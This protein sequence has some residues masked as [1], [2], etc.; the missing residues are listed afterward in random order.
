MANKPASYNWENPTKKELWGGD[1]G[2]EWNYQPN[3][4]ITEII[5]S[6]GYFI[7]AISFKSVDGE[8]KVH[9]SDKY[10]GDG[11]TK[12]IFEIHWPN[13]YL[14]SISGTYDTQNGEYFIRSLRF[15]TKQGIESKSYGHAFGKRF[16][17]SMQNGIIVGFYGRRS[18]LLDAIGV[19]VKPYANL[20]CLTS[21]V[22]MLR[23]E[24]DI[25]PAH[26]LLNV[27]SYSLLPID[28]EE[29]GKYESKFYEFEGY[30]YRWK[31]ILYPNGDSTR[32]GKGHISLYLAIDENNLARDDTYLTVCVDLK[33]FVL[34]NDTKKYL[35]IQDAEGAI[36]YFGKQRTVQGFS[37]LLSIE[38]FKDPSNGYLVDDACT[39]GAE[40]FIIQPSRRTRH[41]ALT[42]FKD[43]L[44][45]THNKD[46]V[47]IQSD[48]KTHTWE[49][50]QFLS[51]GNEEVRFNA[52]NRTW[53]LHIFPKGRD[54]PNGDF[55][56]L[57]LH[58]N[59]PS[60]KVY[61]KATVR[62]VDHLG[63]G[64]KEK[65]ET[66][67][68]W[69]DET[70]K[71]WDKPDITMQLSDIREYVNMEGTLLLQVKFDVISEIK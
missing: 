9:S 6:H 64:S 60:R 62:V 24:R 38:I 47:F 11:G 40:F 56:S 33:F 37:Q 35:T 71:E 68:R 50:T 26:L 32:N 41:E 16:E 15:K 46:R 57:Y 2:T 8:G 49:I 43:P 36:M 18:N 3:G 58:V 48:G 4:P 21:R 44:V 23:E 70:E 45:E 17:Y 5:V 13:D 29:R 67:S 39:F 7:D 22:L 63:N 31:L 65:E 30:P 28:T 55:M 53:F 59:D 19:Y 12:D 66:I 27:K 1:G 20:Y 69:Y 61:V 34:N 52:A 25:Q 54:T 10:G 51:K 14:E 42:L